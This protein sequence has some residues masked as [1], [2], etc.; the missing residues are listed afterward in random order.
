MVGN[1]AMVGAVLVREGNIIAEGWHKEFGHAH[2][3][4]ALLENHEQE[5]RSND[6][7]YLNLE[8]CCHM[9]KA[10]PCTDIL[11]ERGVKNIVVGMLDPDPRVSGRGIEILKSKGVHIVGP[12][13]AEHSERLNRGFVSVR[14]HARPWVTLKQART[15]SGQI[16]ATDR[17]PIKIT[18]KIQDIWSHTFVRALH[19]A[20]LVGI[21]TIL[22][23]DP[24]LDVRCEETDIL[25]KN[26]VHLHPWRI[27]LDPHL[28]MLLESRVVSDAWRKRS[29][30]VT[31]VGEGP[32]AAELRARGVR[33]VTVPLDGE[34]FG[35]GELWRTLITPDGE[36][37]G[38]TSVLVEGG[39]KTW[40]ILRDAG[41][42]DE[43]VIL[44]GDPLTAAR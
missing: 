34:S 7:L 10:P 11:L 42:V 24:L 35:W 39:R 44:V 19:D 33:V 40:D 18:S 1:G 29:M 25:N 8:P 28:R 23:D 22:T 14:R 2:A 37:H 36:Y 3:E 9:G 4:R 20:I 27:V 30:V 17:S 26:I 21:N 5:M 13:L 15:K 41:Y 12:I 6:V 38:L 32:S 16:A 43:E 31:T